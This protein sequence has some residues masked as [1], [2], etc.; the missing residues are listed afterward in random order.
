MRPRGR[1]VSRIHQSP[2]AW[3]AA[4]SGLSFSKN[5]K[6]SP[7]N[8]Q[9]ATTMDPASPMKNNASKNSTRKCSM[10]WVTPLLPKLRAKPLRTYKEFGKKSRYARTAC[11]SERGA[12]L[13]EVPENSEHYQ[14]QSLTSNARLKRFSRLRKSGKKPG[15]SEPAAPTLLPGGVIPPG[16]AKYGT[17]AARWSYS[18]RKVTNWLGM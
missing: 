18:K 13:P 9:I 7:I 14:I 12:M 11:L 2:I 17:L 8:A 15:T 1:E 10:I 5:S 3:L 4:P 16:P 6:Q